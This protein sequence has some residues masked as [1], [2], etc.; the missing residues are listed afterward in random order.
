M[1]IDSKSPWFILLLGVLGGI[2]PLSVDMSLPALTAIDRAFA[3]PAGSAGLTL[4][5]FLIGF[6]A[7]P[8]GFGPLSDRRGRRP[9]LIVAIVLFVLGG[10]VCTIAPSLDLLLAARLLQGAGAGGCMMMTFAI[11]RDLFEGEAARTRLSYV[12]MIFSL[13]P[14]VA[15][16]LGA[17]VLA[18]GGWRSIFGILAVA[19]MC[20]AMLVL[21]GFAESLPPRRRTAAGSP[22][23]QYAR[24]LSN[25]V[26]LG[27]AVVNAFSFG[28]IFAYV[29]GSPLVMIEVLHL[30][31]ALYGLTFAATAFGIL[32]GAFCNARLSARGISSARIALAG[33]FLGGAMSICIC[34]LTLVD[35]VSLPVLLPMLVVTMFACSLVLPNMA[36]AALQPIP[37]LAGAGS[38]LLGSMQTSLGAVVSTLVALF[39]DG[40]TATV[41]AVM[42]AGSALI[43]L[44][45]YLVI[46][47]PAAQR[48]ASVAP[49]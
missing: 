28:C 16:S 13:A 30:A 37:E 42:M 9:V 36:H 20:V 2:V 35:R 45:A 46:A 17:A 40:H 6:A 34:L 7:A 15:P 24:L 33:L 41:M 32:A 14:L 26:Y 43:A 21:F 22:F 25:R 48:A 11:V 12:N 8:M 3:V 1:R 10:L 29:S 39:Y 38:A 44:L 31:P 18:I 4:S 5:L 47:Y 27:H 23:G 19:G 49:V